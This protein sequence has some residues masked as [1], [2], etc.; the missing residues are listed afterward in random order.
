MT[1][2]FTIT[3]TFP[4]SPGEIYRKRLDSNGNAQLIGSPARSSDK[5]REGFR[6]HGW[7]HLRQEA[8]IRA[9]PASHSGY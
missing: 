4:P 5:Q 9:K 1:L 6:S 7:S 8:G 3:E 2:Q